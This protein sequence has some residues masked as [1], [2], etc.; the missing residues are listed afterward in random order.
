MVR[1][2]SDFEKL[3]EFLKPYAEKL[4]TKVWICKKVGKRMSCIARA[5]SE[6]YSEAFVSCEDENY[7]LFTER[8]VTDTVDRELVDELMISFRKLIDK[9]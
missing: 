5:G 7:V 1:E 8:E 2:T 6:N 4:N 9:T 3:S